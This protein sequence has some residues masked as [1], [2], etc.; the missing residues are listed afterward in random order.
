MIIDAHTHIYPDLIAKK[1]AASIGGFYGMPM[2]Y[3]GKMSTLLEIGEKNGID[4]F[5]IQSVA[6]SPKQIDSVT[7]YIS[8]MANKYPDKFIGFTSSHPES[9]NI[10]DEVGK[11]IH[12][13]LKGVKLHPDFQKFNID[14]KN[15]MRIYETIEGR[16]PVLIHTGDFRTEYS[17][18]SR[19]LNVLKAFPKL[20]MIC[21]HFGGWSE[22][23]ESVKILAGTG[24]YVDTCSSQYAVPPEKIREY[25]D[26]YGPDRVIFGS[27]F[28]MWDAGEELRMLEKVFRD[29]NERELIL[30]KNIERLLKL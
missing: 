15:A 7:R 29:E 22:W 10:A 9:E 20:E 12:L 25:I 5:L 19:V 14:D 24:V 1:A 4:K 17:K 28:P 27:D 6:T 2:L 11:A 16:L 30:H 21:A 26:A 8:D 13:G 3:D 18:A 23:E